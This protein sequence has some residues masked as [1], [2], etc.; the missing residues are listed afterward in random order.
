MNIP[1]EA[2]FS[3]G[4]AAVSHKVELFRWMISFPDRALIVFVMLLTL[5]LGVPNLDLSPPISYDEGYVLQAPH[6][7]L[8][9]GFYGTRSVDEQVPFDTH[10]STGPTVLLPVWAMFALLGED[11]APARLVV[12]FYGMLTVAAGYLLMRL[13]Y[14]R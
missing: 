6:N 13:T 4:A 5:V 3:K 1:M 2:A 14:E 8:T 7:L 11:L 12:V 10:V 9:E